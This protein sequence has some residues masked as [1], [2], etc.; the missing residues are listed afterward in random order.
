[1]VKHF[2]QN[3]SDL[4]NSSVGTATSLLAGQSRSRIRFPAG[5]TDGSLLNNVQTCS[6]VYPASYTVLGDVSSG[7]KRQEPLGGEGKSITN[8]IT[9]GKVPVLN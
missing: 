7:I 1:M 9:K 5:A 4:R 6:T 8:L 3:L 2:P